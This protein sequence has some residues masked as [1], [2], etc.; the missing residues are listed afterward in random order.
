MA[1]MYLAGS[2]RPDISF[3]VSKLGQF[4]SKLGDDHWR[5]LEHVMNYLVGSMDYIIYYY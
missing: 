4:T 1:F 3:V 5:V 2:L